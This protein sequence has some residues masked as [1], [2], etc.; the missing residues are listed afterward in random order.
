MNLFMGLNKNIE[1]FA[2][3]NMN[4]NNNREE[5]LKTQLHHCT[6]SD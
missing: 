2:N 6:Y 1:K 5:K 4:S 3:M